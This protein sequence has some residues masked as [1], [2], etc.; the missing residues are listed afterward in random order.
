MHAATWELDKRASSKHR[1][2]E[3]ISWLRFV[4]LPSWVR[5][6]GSRASSSFIDDTLSVLV[7]F[8]TL[9]PCCFQ[10]SQGLGRVKP[11]A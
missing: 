7:F 11:S 9:L 6:T 5:L 2:V 3:I 1:L 4:R 8:D 10:P